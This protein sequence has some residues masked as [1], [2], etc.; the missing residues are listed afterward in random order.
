MAGKNPIKFTDT[1]FRDGHQS[2]LA[3]RMRTEDIVP[4]MERMDQQGFF[5]LEVWG[6]ATFDTTHRFLGDD[7]WERIRTIKSILKKTP[8]MMLLRGQNLVGYRNYA[9]DLAYRFVRYA[10]EA[11]VDIFRVF[12]A[13]NDMRNWEVSV[14]ALMDAKKAGL[15]AHFQAAVCYSMTQRRMGGPIFNLKYYLDFAKRSEAMGADSFCLKDMA[16][17]VSPYDAYEIIK[18]LKETIK[19]PVEFHTHYTS[20]QGSMSY[21]KAIEAGVDVV[22]TCLSPFALRTAQPAIEP[23]LVS[24]EQTDRQTDLDLAQ[25]IEIGQDL[26]KV[27]VKYRDLLDTSKMAQIDTGVLLHQIPGG[28][29]SNLVNQLKEAKALDRIHEVMEELPRTRK[30]LGQPPLVTPTSQIVG[31]QAV[32]NVLFGRYKMVSAEA[33]GVA[34][35]LYGKTPAPIDP[36]IQKAILKGYERGETPITVR[37]GE[38]LEPEWDKAVAATKGLA[39]NDGDV[40]IYALYPTTGSRFLKWKYGMEAVPEEVKGK[41]LEQIKLEDE[42]Y[43]TIKQKNLFAKVKELLATLEK[44]PPA[45]GAGLRTFNVFVDGQYY[46]VEVE[47]LGGAPVLT[48]VTPKAAPALAAAPAPAPAPAPARAPVSTAAAASQQALAA[49]DVP[50]KAPMPGMIISYSVQVG[51]KVASG[52]LVCV[53]EA[54]KMQNSLPAPAAGVVKAIN[55]DP[56]ASVA[57]DTVILV[58]GK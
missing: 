38:I 3:T 56:G 6:G 46:E 20:G 30:E 18:A 43:K 28:M 5:A 57:K 7:P 54:M 48:A 12:D 51:D 47:A 10:A 17:M 42:V 58:I 19:I 52:D 40:L 41:T 11:G 9:D 2:L 53:L 35:G 36:K 32:M 1:T 25:L 24:V 26:E 23:L 34:F 13:L 16:G 45:K 33:K 55:F 50:L 29:Y 49:G 27:V 8:T 37:P 4:F 44:A 22:D 14:K 39:K 15:M 21:L 31:T